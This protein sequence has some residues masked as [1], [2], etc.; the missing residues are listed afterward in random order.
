VN[1]NFARIGGGPKIADRVFGAN[2]QTRNISQ[3]T[4]RIIGFR[5]WKDFCVLENRGRMKLRLKHPLH[6]VLKKR[7]S[8]LN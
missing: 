8:R 2:I 4:F 1:A 3:I 5:K 6:G 7:I